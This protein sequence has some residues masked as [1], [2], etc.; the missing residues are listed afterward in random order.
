MSKALKL[1]FLIHAIISVIFGAI[2]L[3]KPGGFLQWL[4]WWPLDPVVSRVLGAA[5]LA[6]AWGDFRSWWGRSRREV[7]VLIE[8]QLGFAALSAVGLLRHLLTGQ[9]PTMLWIPF[10]VFLL[11]AVAWLAALVSKQP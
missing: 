1:T 6:L 4:H 2:L 5:L 7:T 8:M 9:W 3:V 11:F 10:A